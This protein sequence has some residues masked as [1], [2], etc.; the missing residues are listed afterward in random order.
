VW[1]LA[2]P[3]YKYVT[4]NLNFARQKFHSQT[5]NNDAHLTVL[6]AKETRRE[7]PPTDA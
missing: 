5:L 6:R 7:E 4:L 3:Q 1:A 2:N